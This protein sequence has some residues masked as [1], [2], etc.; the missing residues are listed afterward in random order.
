MFSHA[1]DPEIRV[2]SCEDGKDALS[3][4]AAWQPDVILMDAV[5]PVMDGPEILAGLRRDMRT[6]G[7]P[8]V[9]MTARAQVSEV[10]RFLALGAVGVIAKPFDPLTLAKSVR[11]CL[12]V[13]QPAT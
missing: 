3:Q 2:S 4:A 8:V 7:I 12:G 6:A 5:M 13:R 10:E 11:A 1:L 9:F